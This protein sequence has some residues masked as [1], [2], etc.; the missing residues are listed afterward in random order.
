LL[1]W[2]TFFLVVVIVA[3]LFGVGGMVGGH[4]WIANILSV[5]FVTLFVV[6]LITGRKAPSSGT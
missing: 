6:S 1:R 5:A 4:A 2:A 3:G